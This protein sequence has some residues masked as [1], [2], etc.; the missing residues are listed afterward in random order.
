MQNY[1]A[2][3]KDYVKI[4]SIIRHKDNEQIHMNSI[5]DCMFIFKN[6]WLPLVE[7]TEEVLT[8]ASH[9]LTIDDEY[10]KLKLRIY[11]DRIKL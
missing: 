7:T 2:M 10:E 5:I 3:N 4:L 8:Y 9:C 6:K 11:G 1:Q